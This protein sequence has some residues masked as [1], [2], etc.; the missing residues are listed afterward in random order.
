[1][2]QISEAKEIMSEWMKSL[3]IAF[4]NEKEDAIQLKKI[5]KK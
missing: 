5:R 3:N 2:E 1:M 4:R